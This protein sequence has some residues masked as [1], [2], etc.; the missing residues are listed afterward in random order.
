MTGR[1]ERLVELV[2]V[3]QG[4]TIPKDSLAIF[5][6]KTTNEMKKKIQPS[7]VLFCEYSKGG[8]LQSNL[9]EVVDRLAPLIGFT[10]RVTERGG[11]TLGSMLSNKNLWAG[12]ECGRKECEVCS[13]PG[14]KREDCMR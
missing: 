9:R 14:E 5:K 3:D 6:E 4:T 13:Q 7:T 12:G 2:G 1:V 10:M 8:S 11:T